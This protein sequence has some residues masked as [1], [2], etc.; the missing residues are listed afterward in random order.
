MLDL[1]EKTKGTKDKKEVLL[2]IQDDKK[3]KDFIFP[4]LNSHMT[5]QYSEDTEFKIED[6]LVKTDVD[7][8]DFVDFFTKTIR[9][10]DNRDIT[11][12]S[13]RR[14][15]LDLLSY[16]HALSP[17]NGYKW[18]NRVLCQKLRLGLSTKSFNS[19]Y[20]IKINSCL[21]EELAS[22]EDTEML[23][24]NMKEFN[25]NPKNYIIEPKIDGE[26]LVAI[27]R[28]GKVE[29]M[30]RRGKPK[31]N[32]NVIENELMLLYPNLE[33]GVLDGE[34]YSTNWNESRS[35]LS[36]KNKQ[37]DVSN[38]VFIVFDILSVDIFD[39][40]KSF[41]L[42]SRKR[43][44]HHIINDINKDKNF[45]H[46]RTIPF[47]IVESLDMVKTEYENYK[48]AGFEGCMLKRLDSEYEL[49]RTRNW[50]KVKDIISEEY[51][52]VGIEEGKGKNAGKVGALI[53]SLPNGNHCK[54]SGLTDDERILFWNNSSHIVGKLI[55]VKYQ[56]KTITG[57]LRNPRFV[58]IR[59][60]LVS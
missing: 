32:L 23:T 10:L 34:I 27:F 48:K 46:I 54:V 3:F 19:I 20:K 24:K 51:V 60:D 56:E 5:L 41:P 8:F 42:S 4:A 58:K 26:R 38:L 36:S 30:S 2:E 13:A 50:L 25:E 22:A 35:I 28:N 44:L 14:L 53:I 7:S 9:I 47:K 37:V 59:E 1:I 43:L 6:L 29:L 52:C 18:T 17:S 57:S 11:G 33:N 45:K 12:N 40:I 21:F 39:G 16:A 31:E 55:E 15:I 49:K